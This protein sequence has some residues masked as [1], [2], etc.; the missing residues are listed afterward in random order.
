MLNHESGEIVLVIGN[1]QFGSVIYLSQF[2][3]RRC[4]ICTTAMIENDRGEFFDIFG[5]A[6]TTVD[7]KHS[8]YNLEHRMN[9]G[10][11]ECQRRV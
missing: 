4:V 9:V 7:R 8:E 5:T 6:V 11:H 1:I 3:S 10:L 2:I